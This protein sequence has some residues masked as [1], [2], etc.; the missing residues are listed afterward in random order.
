MSERYMLI[1][2]PESLCVDL[3]RYSDGYMTPERIGDMASGQLLDFLERDFDESGREWFASRALE[4]AEDYFPDIAERWRKANEE[5]AVR[6][7]HQEARPLV[8]KQVTIPHGYEVRMSYGGQDHFALVKDGRIVDDSGAYTP[9]GWA[10]KVAGGTARNAWRDISFKGPFS[11]DWIPAEVLRS[12][13]ERRA[14]F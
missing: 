13:T 1:P 3:I 11:R 2:M 8:W 9:S 14:Q 12:K 7:R 4:F 5:A 10:S 6:A